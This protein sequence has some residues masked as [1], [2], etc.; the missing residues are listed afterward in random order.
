MDILQTIVLAMIGLAGGL[1]VAGGVFSLISILG[2]FPRMTDRL[3]LAPYT[4]QIENIVMLGGTAGSLMTVYK[5]E[6]L[7]GSTFLAIFGIFAGVFVGSLAMALA[8]TLK[9]VPVLCQRTNL[10]LGIS[11]LITAIALGKGF[12][13]LYQMY[14]LGMK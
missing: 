14:I 3:G 5:P 4:R 7:L 6:I 12:G 2:V 1:A 13:T 10:Q 8:E 11:V 9:V